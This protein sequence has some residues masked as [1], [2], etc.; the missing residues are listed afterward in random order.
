M[1]GS[2]AD[3]FSLVTRDREETPCSPVL[4]ETSMLFTGCS[5]R[6]LNAGWQCLHSLAAGEEAAHV[7]A[8]G[9]REEVREGQQGSPAA[10][11]AFP[12]HLWAEAEPQAPTTGSRQLLPAPSVCRSWH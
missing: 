8:T 1:H 2:N 5:L 4:I 7:T 11:A 6:M 3:A 9:S 12:V 10:D